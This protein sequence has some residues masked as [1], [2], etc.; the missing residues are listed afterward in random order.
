MSPTFV[1]L[2]PPQLDTPDK[3]WL[4]CPRNEWCG[5]YSDRW[6]TSIINDKTRNLYLTGNGGLVLAPTAKL[7]CAY[8]E[9]CARRRAQHASGTLLAM[10]VESRALELR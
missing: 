8:P 5:K 3:P 9:E 4:A 7:F 6:A 1:P 2:T 10:S